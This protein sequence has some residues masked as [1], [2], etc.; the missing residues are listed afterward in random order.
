M[1]RPGIGRVFFG[2]FNA[3]IA[4][5]AAERGATVQRVIYCLQTL[6]ICVRHSP[7]WLS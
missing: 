5:Q 1:A 3:E 6:A 4:L 2:D 7:F